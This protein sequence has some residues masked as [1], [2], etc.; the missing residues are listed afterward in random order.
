MSKTANEVRASFLE[1]FKQRGHTVCASAPLIPQNDPTLMFAN[2]GMV[3]FKDVFTGKESRPFT[4]ASS[5][6]KCIR[7]SGKH[8]DL[9]N[10]GVTARHH[11]F[12]EML[13]NFSFGDYFKEDAIAW[14]WELVTGAWGIE[15]NRLVV[16]IFGGAD[17][18]PA[19]DE[20]RAIWRKVTG[21][22]DA[23]ILGIPGVPGDNFWQMGETGPC[24]PCTELHYFTGDMSGGEAPVHSFGEEP[25]PD[26]IGWMEIWNLVF[27]QFERSKKE[28]VENEYTLAPL[29]KPC[30]DTG[31][32]LERVTSV[33]QGKTS[34]Y[35]TDL[36]RA[37]VEKSA[38]ISGKTYRGTQADDDVSMRVI[39]DHAR[40][41]A[42][43]IAEGVF[44][45]RADRP[46]VLR[47]V[48][49][50]AIRHGHRL[51]IQKPFLHEVALEVVKLMGDQYPELRQYK[52]TIASVAEQ[53]EVRFRE[54]IERGLKL[55]DEEIAQMRARNEKTIDGKTVFKLY[56]TFGFP[57]DLTEVI[58]KER[59]LSI[60]VLGYNEA[61]EAQRQRSEGSKVGEEALDKVLYELTEKFPH[62]TKF[63]GYEREEG[64]GKIV[65]LIQGGKL[66]DEA[67][68][69]GADESVGIVTDQTPFYG[70]SGGQVGDTGG[71]KNSANGAWAKITDTQKPLGG[72]FVHYATIGGGTLKVGDTVKLEVA[73]EKR[74]ATRR[75]H[76]ATHLLHYALKKVLGDT[77]VQKGSLVGPDRLRF[78]FSHGRAVT[79]EEL[80]KIEDLVNEKVLGDAPVVTEV[81]A[82]EEA[83]KR[84]AV[85]MFGEKYGATVRVLTMTKDSVEFCGGTHARSLGEIGLF[86]I[87]S[88]GGVAAGVRRI[89][90]ATGMNALSYVRD[91]ES[92]VKS[93]ARLVKAAPAELEE[94]L[95]KLVEHERALEKELHEAKRKAALGGGGAAGAAG[96][97]ERHRRH[98]VEGARS[99]ERAGGRRQNGLRARRRDRRGD[100]ARAGRKGAR[101]ARRSGGARR[102]EGRRQG[103]ARV[104][105]VEGPH[106]EGPRRRRHQADRADRRRLRRWPAGHGASGRH[107]GRQAR[108]SVGCTLHTTVVNIG[109]GEPQRRKDA[110]ERAP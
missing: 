39:A 45:D 28:G 103:A 77:A 22:P 109:G 10:V 78:D 88:E 82:I 12:F 51:G 26:G 81:L 41:T 23:R 48:M 101:Q 74:T 79:H 91:L 9:E 84:G 106:A 64:E 15:K 83:K 31:A 80:S 56:D 60:D 58:A 62:G 72:V 36:L 14:A 102:R 87:L 71:L 68:E 37:L 47:R 4:R 94:K 100:A 93:A 27:M 5:S 25:T 40:T 75:N 2:A 53:E 65:A 24:G 61:L 29:P 35:D 69:G 97:G 108:R 63:L 110:K 96:G 8:N 33:L 66:V 46:Y 67:G 59:D 19:D 98:R 1:F 76:S 34:N 55:L 50:R 38:E 44:P 20:A 86:K 107:A 3:P 70:E 104:R 85:A 6:Q 90:A 99:A 18:V 54:T 57:L 17:G 32:G 52:D 30:V 16:T 105:G 7:I 42:F 21:F 49:R 89:E 13:G 92:K 73:H 95:Q 11:T 43:L